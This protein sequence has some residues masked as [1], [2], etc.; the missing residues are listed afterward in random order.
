MF[1]P[2]VVFGVHLLSG[3]LILPFSITFLYIVQVFEGHKLQ[4]PY[5]LNLK[6]MQCIFSLQK[7]NKFRSQDIQIIYLRIW[8]E[9]K[10]WVFP[11]IPAIP[12]YE[13][14]VWFWNDVAERIFL[15]FNLNILFFSLL[16]KG[17]VTVINY[18]NKSVVFTIHGNSFQWYQKC[19]FKWSIFFIWLIVFI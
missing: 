11:D 18:H 17:N 16:I 13:N 1:W 15:H 2:N 7:W 4:T 3:Y 8:I 19:N 14:F 9:K 10:R 6:R 5:L 12:F